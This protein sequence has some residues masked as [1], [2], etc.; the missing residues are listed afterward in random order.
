MSAVINTLPYGLKEALDAYDRYVQDGG[1]DN[2]LLAECA[3]QMHNVAGEFAHFN[4]LINLLS[5]HYG[6]RTAA[7]LAVWSIQLQGNYGNYP[8]DVKEK[9]RQMAGAISAAF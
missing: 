9:I 7:S 8:E 3:S 6:D 4:P 2:T 5:G 1:K